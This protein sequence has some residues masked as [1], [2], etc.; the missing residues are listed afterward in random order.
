M[1]VV[2]EMHVTVDNDCRD[3]I[4]DVLLWLRYNMMGRYSDRVT[5]VR[6]TLGD[7]VVVEDMADGLV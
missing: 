6:A 7:R 5:V 4:E 2:V 3:A 1:E